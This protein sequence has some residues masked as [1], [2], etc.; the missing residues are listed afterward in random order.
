MGWEK[1][2]DWYEV[3]KV[4]LTFISGGYEKLEQYF[5]K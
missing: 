2:Q 4:L 5:A 1:K 3:Q